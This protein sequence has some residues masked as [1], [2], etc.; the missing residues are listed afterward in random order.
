MAK[1]KSIVVTNAGLELIAAAQSGDT[2]EFTA[3]KSGAGVYDGTEVLSELT[4]LKDLK[5]TFGV[6]GITRDET[7]IKVRSVIDNNGLGAGY[8][9]TEIGLFAKDKSNNEILYA[10]VVAETGL[11][12]YLPAYADA[13]TT[14]T[15][16]MYIDVSSVD[17][18]VEFQA[19]IIPGTYVTV[20]DFEDYRAQQS[21]YED[22]FVANIEINGTTITCKNK[23]GEILFSGET[24]D[25]TYSLATITTAGLMDPIDKVKLNGIETGAQ[26][27]TITGVKGSAESTYRTGEVNITKGNIGLGNVD[28]TSDIDK[29]VSTA[30]QEALDLK[31]DNTDYE[32][33]VTATHNAIEKINSNLVG[34]TVVVF[35]DS[36]AKA[37][38]SNGGVFAK[39]QEDYDLTIHNY[40]ENGAYMVDG[41]TNNLSDQYGRM[42]AD[43]I[44]PDIMVFM[45]HFNELSNAH[46]NMTTFNSI[47][48][49]QNEDRNTSIGNLEYWMKYTLTNYPTCKMCYIDYPIKIAQN[50]RSFFNAQFEY[51]LYL[52]CELYGVPICN[53]KNSGISF[54]ENA[55]GYTT[56]GLHFSELAVTNILYPFIKGFLSSGMSVRNEEPPHCIGLFGEQKNPL[57][58]IIVLN[59]LEN[60]YGKKDFARTF[61]GL[62]FY[63]KEDT[64]DSTVRFGHLT[65]NYNQLWGSFGFYYDCNST[66]FKRFNYYNGTY[67]EYNLS[68][69]YSIVAGAK[70]G[71]VSSGSCSIESDS[72]HIKIT[73]ALTVDSENATSEIVNDKTCL[74][75]FTFASNDIFKSIEVGVLKRVGNICI[76]AFSQYE[77]FYLTLG[78][79]VNSDYSAS[80]Y[81]V[82][83][84]TYYDKLKTGGCN[85]FT[86][87]TL[88][89]A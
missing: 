14:I 18:S 83:A 81:I 72:D 41:I 49:P 3:I 80:L 11:E 37:D 64:T 16:E 66:T 70:T 10:I 87:K 40:A 44:T 24:K 65:N 51:A 76:S 43:G 2:I 27:N 31:V 32:A 6:T 82:G 69:S 17:S 54:D 1:Y 75:L 63:T 77:P 61:D 84:E 13:P 50:P 42:V 47:G 89:N 79:L 46:N 48:F 55:S 9:I 4:G 5:Q 59:K 26:K 21:Q 52:L 45:F 67:G 33:E 53:M 8:N 25:T 57:N 7:V 34:K 36:I 58:Y 38:H 71:N 60:V 15:S 29:P 30:Q 78:L 86:C 19:T 39:L 35:G 22:S 56:D 68:K 20:Q 88:S 85:I 12:D 23:D 73:A 28:N 74:K 62:V